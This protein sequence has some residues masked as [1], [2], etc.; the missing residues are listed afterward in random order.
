MRMSWAGDCC[1]LGAVAGGKDVRGTGAAHL[2]SV[3]GI[4]A[5]V[6]DEV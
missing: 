1:G 2:D 4:E 6:V 5:Q 3:Q